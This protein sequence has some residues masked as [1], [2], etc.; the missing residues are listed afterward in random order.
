[1]RIQISPNSCPGAP[2]VWD[3]SLINP[4]KGGPP[5]FPGDGITFG[6][7]LN[8]PRSRGWIALRDANPFSMPRI[9]TNYYTDPSDMLRMIS[10][11][12]L[13]RAQFK[14]RPLADE[15]WC[16]SEVGWDDEYGR[17][18]GRTDAEIEAYI[19]A[20]VRRNL[21]F[22]FRRHD[23]LLLT[24]LNLSPFVKSCRS[25]ELAD[26]HERRWSRA[27]TPGLRSAWDSMTMTIAGLF[28]EEV[29]G[30]GVLPSPIFRYFRRVLKSKILKDK[31]L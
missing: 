22:P 4:P 11:V 8:A 25:R 16:A 5:P 2:S 28:C 24:K 13:A 19:R 18:L 23:R 26:G 30:F 7:V 31:V 6:I 17:F 10:A 9:F 27:K 14:E 1:M 20:K 3:Q 29:L 21:R 15:P 12:K